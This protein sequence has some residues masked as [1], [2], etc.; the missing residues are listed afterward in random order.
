MYVRRDSPTVRTRTALSLLK[1][2]DVQI[3]WISLALYHRYH[4]A[5]CRAKIRRISR[6]VCGFQ[7]S[8]DDHLH[9]LLPSVLLSHPVML[10]YSPLTAD[11]SI[12]PNSR[13]VYSMISEISPT[14]FFTEKTSRDRS[15]RLFSITCSG[16]PQCAL[17]S[18]PTLVQTLCFIATTSSHIS[19]FE[20][21]CPSYDGSGHFCSRQ[22]FLSPSFP[23]TYYSE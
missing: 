9:H 17:P 1:H 6:Q 18:M 8:V 15:L 13:P 23:E 22:T 7:T 16:L 21:G 2:E 3:A 4:S 10:P 12:I 5:I 11:Q 19:E 14:I 20:T